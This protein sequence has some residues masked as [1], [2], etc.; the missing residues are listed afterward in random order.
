MEQVKFLLDEKE[1]PKRWY[2]I[3]ADLKD[4]LRVDA[5]QLLVEQENEEVS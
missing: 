3:V 4:A 2:N 5:V 1:M